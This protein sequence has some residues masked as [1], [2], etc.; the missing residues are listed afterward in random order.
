[1]NMLKKNSRTFLTT[2]AVCFALLL[3]LGSSNYPVAN[4]FVGKHKKDTLVKAFNTTTRVP[5][6]LVK[7][8]QED[9]ASS[10][11][12]IRKISLDVKVVGNIATTIMDI[13]F[14]NDL[15]RI[16]DGE[17]CFPLGEGQSVSYFAMEMPDGL[18]EASVV[19]KAKGRIV[20]ETIVRRKVDPALMEWT[21]GNNFRS[22]VY[23]IPAKG[24]KRILVG[25]EQEL[26]SNNGSYLYYQPFS[27]KDKVDEFSIRTEVF[28]QE[29]KPELFGDER[30]TFDFDKWKEN[31]VAQKSM[32]DYV[33]DKPLAFA[34]PR[35]KEKVPVFVERADKGNSA[36]YFT[37][38]PSIVKEGRALPSKVGLL[39]DVSGSMNKTKMEDILQCVDAFMKKAL[40]PSVKF[41]SFSN[42]IIEATSYK[43]GE[44]EWKKVMEKMNSIVPDG[45]TQLGCLDLAKYDCD[46]FILI[47]DGISNFG[48]S[49]IKSSAK[50]IH[51]ICSSPTVDYSY[52]KYLSEVTGGNYINLSNVKQAEALSLLSSQRYRFISAEYDKNVLSGVFPSHPTDITGSFS[53]AGILEGY[54]SNISINFGI[55]NKILHTEKITVT[56]KPSDYSNMVPKLWAQKKIAEMDIFYEKNKDAITDVAKQYGIVTRNTSL[57]ILD[58]LEDY[59]TYKVIPKDSELKK[60]YLQRVDESKNNFRTEYNIHIEQVVGQFKQWAE[61]YDKDYA[62]VKPVKKESNKTSMADSVE[63]GGYQRSQ[64]AVEAVSY[65]PPL[66]DPNTSTNSTITREEVQNVSGVIGGTPAQLSAVSVTSTNAFNGNADSKK[67]KDGVSQSGSLNADIAVGSWSPDAEYMHELK[68]T[69]KANLYVKYLELKPKYM[70]TPSFFLDVSDYF[71]KQGEETLALRILSNIAELEL[72]N[73]QLL[74]VLAHRLQQLNK[75]TLAINV[76]EDV[77]KIREEEP[78]SY[79]D[80]GLAYEQNKEYQK[81][82]DVLCKVI[83]RKWDGRFPGVETLVAIEINHLISTCGKKLQ[84]DSLDTRL[85]K[86]MSSDVRV[87]INWDTDNCDMDLWV[88]DPN[89][90]KCFYS[91]ALTAS[92]GKMTRDFTGG[93]GPEVFMIKKAAEGNYKIEANYFG[94]SNQSL[95]GPTT[96][97]AELYTNYGRANEVKKTITLRL[98]SKKEVVSLADL[99]FSKK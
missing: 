64:E 89:K 70:N 34:I 58:G 86:P 17:F 54:S 46:E 6:L 88:T 80:L 32:K 43:S 26:T 11:L 99:L 49:Q 60:Q 40:Y 47:S 48:E 50:P 27:F 35:S 44:Q 25:F 92:G 90:E 63:V 82:V 4:A 83:N 18:R 94:T 37:I 8:K 66:M 81:A 3:V 73:H 41:V 61:W 36:F 20:Y 91:H 31:W 15:D 75:N 23:P 52:L 87:V 53:M 5:T 97:Q 9:E 65:S 98:E 38:E 76:F 14:Y 10:P 30:I 93:Y 12:R 77:M 51:T 19:E 71:M 68:E 85:I 29:V 69:P 16:L 45:G 95:T 7:R 96:L 79:R 22:R 55:G 28:S 56:N 72:E 33:A 13:T 57:L 78:Q 2:L 21:A 24:T 42:D 62:Y 39:F 84:L 59:I 1:M 74:R 67:S